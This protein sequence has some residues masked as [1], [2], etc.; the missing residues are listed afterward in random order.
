MSWLRGG[1]VL[2]FSAVIVICTGVVVL[3]G[4]VSGLG[5]REGVDAGL[6]DRV[7][8]AGETR[9]ATLTEPWRR[10]ISSRPN[11]KIS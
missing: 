4:G 2:G 9:D 11:G 6:G 3:S 7:E 8:G 1:D 10:S 5:E